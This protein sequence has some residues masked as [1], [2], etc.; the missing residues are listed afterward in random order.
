VIINLKN[1]EELVFSDRELAKLFPA[2]KHLFDQWAMGQQHSALKTLGQRS[3]LQFL[4]GL[5]DDDIKIFEEYF[6]ENIEVRKL[7]HKIV[8]TFK[9]RPDEVGNAL[10]ELDF[11]GW[12]LS[13]YRDAN[14]VYIC[15]WR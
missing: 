1:I 5:K 8:K 10:R 14:Y 2:K 6:Q 3:V 15:A 12:Q 13:T 4:N 11:I 9:M 7:D